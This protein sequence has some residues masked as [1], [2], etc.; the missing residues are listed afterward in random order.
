MFIQIQYS[1]TTADRVKGSFPRN[2]STSE[3]N[4]LE[5]AA[6]FWKKSGDNIL[7]EIPGHPGKW[8]KKTQT[9]QLKPGKTVPIFSMKKGGRIAG[10]EITP[11]VALNTRFKDLILRARWDDEPV[12]AINSPLGD[13]FGYAFGVPSMKSLLSGVKDGVHYSYLP[14]PFDKKATLEIEYLKNDLN[15]MGEIPVSV[16]IYYSDEK[17]SADEGKLYV[18][19]RREHNPPLGEPYLLLKKQGRGHHVGTLLQSQGLN[20]GMTLFFEGD[21]Q[22]FIDGEL[23]LHGTGSEDYFNGGWYAL[24]D[25]WDQAFSLPVHGSLD[26]SIALA[27]TGGYRFLITD[28]LSFGKDFL[29][30]MEHGG[31]NNSVP[32]DYASVVFYYCDTPPETNSLP[33]VDLLKPI[34]SPD[35]MEY[36]VQLLP[37]QALSHGARLSHTNVRL[38]ANGPRHDVYRVEA[39]SN[40]FAKFELEVPSDGDYKLYISYLKGPECGTFDVNQRQIPIKTGINGYAPAYTF[41]EKEFIGDMHIEKGTNTITMM[42]KDKPEHAEI[43]TFLLQRIYLEKINK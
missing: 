13:F 11:A 34:E 6:D 25:R 29:L 28:K 5:K 43:N 8:Q 10:I 38:P 21:D 30:T 16:T 37:I 2:F 32:V 15:A 14:M 41:V 42:L 36:W 4:A 7:S 9:F 20:P 12:P 22:C 18:E 33:T 40:G 35:L 24:A 3:R 27:R 26:Y 17:R 23:R 31:E 39:P 1:E 19:W